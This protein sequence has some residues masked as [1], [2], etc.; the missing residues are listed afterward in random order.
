MKIEIENKKAVE[1]SIENLEREGDKMFDEKDS[2]KES[3]NSE[4]PFLGFAIAIVFIVA[5]GVLFFGWEQFGY[6]IVV[7]LLAMIFVLFGFAFLGIEITDRTHEAAATDLGIGLAFILSGLI[8]G[9]IEFPIS[10]NLLVLIVVG[11]GALFVLTSIFNLFS[12]KRNTKNTD[13]SFLYKT[14]IVFGQIFGSGLAIYEF[15]RFFLK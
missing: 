15:L 3:E 1:K 2:K 14:L 4:D 11:I 13:L 5:G 7:K 9:S 8:F 10:L 6:E 12:K